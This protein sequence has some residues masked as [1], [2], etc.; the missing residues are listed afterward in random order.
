MVLITVKLSTLMLLKAIQFC[1]SNENFQSSF[2][3]I[4]I[5]SFVF[6]YKTTILVISLS[7]A[8]SSLNVYGKNRGDLFIIYFI[9]FFFTSFIFL[10]EKKKR[11]EEDKEKK[12]SSLHREMLYTPNKFSVDSPYKTRGCLL[13]SGSC[14]DHR[15]F[16]LL[17]SKS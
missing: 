2:Y 8:R 5:S 7:Q 13:F 1:G 14:V 10:L 17:S 16:W 11:E 4:R 12:N 15:R 6:I 3:N 9:Y